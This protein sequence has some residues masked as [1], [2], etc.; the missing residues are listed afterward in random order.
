[1]MAIF[2]LN[3]VAYV[4][5]LLYDIALSPDHGYPLQQVRAFLV[6][7]IPYLLQD[8]RQAKANRLSGFLIGQHLASSGQKKFA[9]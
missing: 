3:N 5:Y 7:A 6:A 8:Y 9:Q 1:M 2:V 4:S